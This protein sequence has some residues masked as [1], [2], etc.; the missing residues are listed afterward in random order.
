MEQGSGICTGSTRAQ[1]LVLG[2]EWVV[3]LTFPENRSLFHIIVSRRGFR[4]F[5]QPAN[6]SPWSRHLQDPKESS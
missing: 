5:P 4:L 6:P 3:V 1:N 2:E